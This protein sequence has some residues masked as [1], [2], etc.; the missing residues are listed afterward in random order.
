[1]NRLDHLLLKFVQLEGN[2][3]LVHMNHLDIVLNKILWLLGAFEILGKFLF[4]IVM[5]NPGRL[6]EWVA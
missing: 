2:Q 6:Q 3:P 1:M 5:R 4:G